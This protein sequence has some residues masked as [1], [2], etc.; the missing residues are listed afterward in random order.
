M[1]IL[2]PLSNPTGGAVGFGRVRPLD[3][4]C[5]TGSE[6]VEVE[7][8]NAVGQHIQVTAT[9]GGCV[10]DGVTYTS[11]QVFNMSRTKS[12]VCSYV[13]LSGYADVSEGDRFESQVTLIWEPVGGGIVHTENGNVWRAAE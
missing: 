3:W 2:E 4:T 10:Y 9:D 1:G 6:T 11:G 5:K 8:I 13:G 12:A 7:W